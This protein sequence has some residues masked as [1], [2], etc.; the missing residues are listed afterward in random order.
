ML[1]HMYEG[2]GIIKKKKAGLLIILLFLIIGLGSFVFANPD[3]QENFEEGETEERDRLDGDSDTDDNG[4]TDSE[5]S[6]SNLLT[7]GTD[8]QSD[9]N[10]NTLPRN[11][12]GNYDG[13][14]FTTGP[15]GNDNGPI[16]VE[17][18]YYADA[19]KA[20]E[21][22]ES[23]LVQGDVDYASSLVDK[24]TNQSQKD[25][26]NK[27]LDAVQDII[28]VTSLIE[29]LE[30]MV[31]NST[32]RDGIVESIT[33]RDDEKIEELVNDLVNGDAKDD[34]VD[35]L[36]AVN[37]ILND[38]KGPVISGIENNSFTNDD[39]SLTISDDNEVTTTVTLD[40]NP[41]DYADTF[42]VEGTYVV[43]VV[44]KAFNE[45]SKTFTIDRTKPVVGGVEDGKYYNTDHDG[46]GNVDWWDG[47][48]EDYFT[49]D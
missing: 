38:N 6:E 34:L 36:E 20:V 49:I 1:K 12:L 31:A 19:L 35:R 16:T 48:L 23:S 22:A 17:Y 42:D 30:E 4:N 5:E 45:A 46:D 26:L 39:V 43:T 15:S 11:N 32:N 10:Q 18:D 13:T 9:N 44:D 14:G 2:E 27:R 24:V 7:D 33:Y 47:M 37:K 8:S 29:R 21:N 28:D 25:E 41:V 3:N 40:G